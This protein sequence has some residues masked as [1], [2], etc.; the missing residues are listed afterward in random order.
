M[1]TGRGALGAAGAALVALVACGGGGH[2]ETDDAATGG[3]CGVGIP[4][5]QACNALVDV[6]TI[7]TTTCTTGTVPIGAGGTIV[8]GTYVLTAQTQY[9]GFSC[10]GQLGAYSET[11]EIARGCME[12]LGASPNF[13][14]TASNTFTVAGNS[15]TMTPTCYTDQGGAALP[16]VMTHTFTATGATLKLIANYA[17][18]ASDV[19]EYARQ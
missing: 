13:P 5:G 12:S 17:S 14:F 2:P 1:E 16:P 6:G 10:S 3:A 15:I 11:M 4:V 18:G 8:D 19:Y 7:V 9:N